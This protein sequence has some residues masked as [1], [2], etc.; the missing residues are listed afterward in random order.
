MAK[1]LKDKKTDEPSMKELKKK[2]IEK[3]KEQG[4]SDD[5]KKETDDR[6]DNA[7]KI[8]SLISEKHNPNLSYTDIDIK[9]TYYDGLVLYSITVFRN[10]EWPYNG[11]VPCVSVSCNALGRGHIDFKY[12]EETSYMDGDKIKHEAFAELFDL[13]IDS[14]CDPEVLDERVFPDD[15]IDIKVY[16]L[17][18]SA[19]LGK[20]PNSEFK[21]LFDT[22]FPG[23]EDADKAKYYLQQRCGETIRTEV[24]L[25]SSAKGF[26]AQTDGAQE[27]LDLIKK[28]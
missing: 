25:F 23:I 27:L 3:L 1:A 11:L 5:T 28:S 2:I 4:S 20:T 13:V 16:G 18:W 21:K 10:G 7:V 12:K 9:A 22:Y 6:I 24:I 14:V 8:L 15:V 26:L 19:E 17:N